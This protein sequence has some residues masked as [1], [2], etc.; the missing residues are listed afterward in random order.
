MMAG[1]RGRAGK[2]QDGVIQSKHFRRQPLPSCD[3]CSWKNG[4]PVSPDPLNFQK[5]EIRIYLKSNFK[6]LAPNCNVK[7]DPS[8]LNRGPSISAD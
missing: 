7:Y 8:Q 6:I 2:G 3:Q 1:L 4:G 5:L